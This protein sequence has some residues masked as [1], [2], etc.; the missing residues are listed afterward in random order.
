[1]YVCIY[2]YIYIYIYSL[3]SAPSPVYLYLLPTSPGA[4]PCF[5]IAYGLTPPNPT[6]SFI[7]LNMEKLK[8]NP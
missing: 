5:G 2:I 3:V 4:T 7:V 8:S 1:M 6:S